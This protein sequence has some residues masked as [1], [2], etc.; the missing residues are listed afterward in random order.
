MIDR[1]SYIRL[2]EQSLRSLGYED[3]ALALEKAS[4]VQQSSETAS[5]F[6]EAVLAGEVDVA[7]GLLG[8]LEG[9]LVEKEVV[10]ASRASRTTDPSDPR[11]EMGE[12]Q[13]GVA[14]AGTRPSLSFSMPLSPRAVE[15]VRRRVRRRVDRARHLLYCNMF[16]AMV[17][18]G[19][20]GK[21][22]KC[23]RE[24]IQPLESVLQAAC[25]GKGV[26]EGAPGND[27]DHD[28]RME[29]VDME[30]GAPEGRLAAM[31]FPSLSGLDGLRE[32]FGDFPHT[33][34]VLSTVPASADNAT[35]NNGGYRSAV[36]PVT[37]ENVTVTVD[38]TLAR[39]TASDHINENNK[40]N[41]A[42]WGSATHPSLSALAAMLLQANRGAPPLPPKRLREYGDVDVRRQEQLL[43]ELQQMLSP[44][45]LIP[46][47]RLETLVEQALMSQ[48]HRCPYHNTSDTTLSLM[49]D[50][51]A[52]PDS[53]PTVPVHTLT[54]HADEV[55]VVQFSP[56]G[57]WLVSA[58]KDGSAILWNV[59]SS[60]KVVFSRILH[61]GRVPIN[62]GAFSPTSQE[63][64]IGSNDGKIRVFEVSSGELI[65]E[66]S[67]R[68]GTQSNGPLAASPG[69]LQDASVSSAM[70][71]NSS[72]KIALSCNKELRM[73]D[74][75]IDG[76]KSGGNA[77][78]SAPA[79]TVVTSVRLQNHAY[80]SVL[81]ADG[82][83]FV[84]VGQDRMI[85]YVRVS[86]GMVVT[87]GPEP[88]AVTCLSRSSDG[89][90]LASNLANGCIHIWQL[91]HLQR[92]EDQ[93]MPGDVRSSD[94]EMATRNDGHG[95]GAGN[96]GSNPMPSSF[97]MDSP[98]PMESLPLRPLYVLKGLQTSQPGRFVI[99]SAFGGVDN[100]FVGT[101]SENALVHIWNL[102]SEKLLASME[103]HQA[104][105]N[106]VAWNPCNPHMLASASDDHKVIIWLS[107]R[108]LT[109]EP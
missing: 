49:S 56:D 89:K 54:L 100:V 81:S 13:R 103:G 16:R 82:G 99:R 18:A 108:H 36:A 14:R 40:N 25:S 96:D 5:R 50:Y 17:E 53:L 92:V 33:F 58:S 74:V 106:A 87:R 65:V 104:T 67:G 57:K 62:I 84:S 93:G 15:S 6:R 86:D 4:N 98:D 31:N 101:G 32:S 2:L 48:I 107:Q 8:E 73:I 7:L 102:R 39:N 29:D 85:R 79:S 45:V 69:G 24:D 52:G 9:E 66:L 75:D 34:G 20:V 42:H 51:H 88:A 76:W 41:N 77:S 21:A 61:S 27:R 19:E 91:G 43:R 64:L 78:S 35:T 30:G 90:Y 71:G 10:H 47:N 28:H 22:L 3:V 109:E 97:D 44:E 95:R 12:E 37:T 23:L 46:D 63:V 11:V 55:W 83:T 80:D 105:V 60:K 38:A 26:Q 72:S 94:V 1:V 68:S 59:Q 70:W